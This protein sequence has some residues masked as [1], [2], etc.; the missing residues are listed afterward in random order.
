M[1]QLE[2]QPGTAELL[3]TNIFARREDTTTKSHP[4]LLDPTLTLPLARGGNVGLPR[5]SW[6]PGEARAVPHWPA[7]AEGPPRADATSL[8]ENR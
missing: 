1:T 5:V 8:P 7:T 4:R 3:S 2:S 6:V